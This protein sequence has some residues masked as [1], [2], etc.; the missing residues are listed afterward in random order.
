MEFDYTQ[1]K[2]IEVNA[3][4]E[5]ITFNMEP[6]TLDEPS[7]YMFT[8]TRKEDMANLIASYSPAHRN[9][10]QVGVAAVTKRKATEDEKSRVLNELRQSRKELVES[11]MLRK[12]A[13]G[14]GVQFFCCFFFFFS[15]PL[16]YNLPVYSM[17]SFIPKKTLLALVFNPNTSLSSTQVSWPP[18]CAAPRAPPR[19]PRTRILRKHS[20]SSTGLT[21]SPSSHSLCRW[22]VDFGC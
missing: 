11:G 22:C 14:K 15:S 21:P 2:N 6:R 12:P 4:D 7:H 9:W 1:L 20:M 5:T 10:K 17:C 18:R 19:R 13:E 3:Y 8:C 16:V